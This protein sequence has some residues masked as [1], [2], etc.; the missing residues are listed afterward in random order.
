MQS[1]LE[2]KRFASKVDG[3]PSGPFGRPFSI[4]PRQ[5]RGAHWSKTDMIDNGTIVSGR[6]PLII[7]NCGCIPWELVQG[8]C[9]VGKGTRR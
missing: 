3:P 1:Q 2:S 4:L 8:R 6:R 5:I 7:L 9:W